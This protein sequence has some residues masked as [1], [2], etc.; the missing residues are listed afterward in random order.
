M[1]IFKSF[2]E[3]HKELTRELTHNGLIVNVETVQ[4]KDVKGMSEYTTKELIGYSFLVRDTSKKS[5]WLKSLGYNLDWAKEEFEERVSP[6]PINPGRAWERREKAWS[7]FIHNG[8]FSYTYNE[9][10]REQLNEI[11]DL[12]N[13]KPHSRQ[14]IITIY[15][16]HSDLKNAGGQRRIPCSMYY[17]FFIREGKLHLIYNIRSNDFKEHFPYDVW[18]A[19]EMQKYVADRNRTVSGKC[20]DFIYFCGSLHTFMRDSQEMF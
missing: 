14:A 11:I 12:L 8:K 4:D 15:D 18:L 17:Q 16:Q 6:F 20:G 10:I 5:E 2:D 13:T 1:R 9:R 7:E 19:A 3:M